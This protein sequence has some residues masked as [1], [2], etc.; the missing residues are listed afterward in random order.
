MTEE[1]QLL[2]LSKPFPAKLVKK[3]PQG[4]YG[5]YAT[6]SSYTQALLAIIGPFSFRIVEVIKGDEM[7]DG[8]IGELSMF[9]DGHKVVVQEAGECEHPSLKQT[10]GARLKDASSDAFK[11]CCMRTG[12]GLHLWAQDDYILHTLL[13]E[14]ADASVRNLEGTPDS[15]SPEAVGG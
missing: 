10:N 4:K 2:R 12:L 7:I 5:T 1:S 8:C 11:R 3:A 6:H 13:K 9:V 15:G 14:R